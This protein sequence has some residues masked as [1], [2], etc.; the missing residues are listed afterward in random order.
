V[1]A[2]R[3]PAA[4]AKTLNLFRISISAKHAK[5]RRVNAVQPNRVPRV[6]ASE[7]KDGDKPAYVCVFIRLNHTIQSLRIL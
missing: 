2:A 4:T 5:E 7:Q 1:P 6:A 3:T